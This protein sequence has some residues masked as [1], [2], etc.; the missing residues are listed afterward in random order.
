M[1]HIITCRPLT[2][3]HLTRELEQRGYECSKV[4]YFERARTHP[5][6]MNEQMR[7]VAR[8]RWRQQE[9]LNHRLSSPSPRQVR[10]LQD[11]NAQAASSTL[12][13][14]RLQTPF[15]PGQPLHERA[16]DIVAAGRYR[17]QCLSQ[18]QTRLRATPLRGRLNT[19]PEARVK[20]RQAHLTPAHA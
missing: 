18:T 5:A 7:E 12:Y 19:S 2:A 15:V 16:H 6:N 14:F 4:F 20:T 10:I 9:M 3:R 17:E 11:R 1:T 8:R 13:S